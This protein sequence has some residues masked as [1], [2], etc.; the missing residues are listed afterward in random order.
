M[1]GRYLPWGLGGLEYGSLWRALPDTVSHT[2][3]PYICAGLGASADR[4]ALIKP[5]ALGW[6]ALLDCRM[7]MTFFFIGTS[8]VDTGI[9]EHRPYYIHYRPYKPLKAPAFCIAIYRCIE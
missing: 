8:G 4:R 3:L 5:D 2:F 6:P 1:P 9:G 7:R